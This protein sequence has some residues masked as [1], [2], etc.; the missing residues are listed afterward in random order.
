MPEHL[1]ILQLAGA[2]FLTL[3]GVAWLIGVTRLLRR[4]RFEAALGHTVITPLSGLPGPRTTGPH[5]EAVELTPAEQAAF[6]G[7]V[8]QLSDGR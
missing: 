4:F 2:A 1:S 8:R 7:L 5:R 3:A 6:A